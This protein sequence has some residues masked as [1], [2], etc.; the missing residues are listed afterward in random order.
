[1]GLHPNW[2]PLLRERYAHAFLTEVPSHDR[3]Q[4]AQVMLI[5]FL[6]VLFRKSASIRTGRHFLNFVCKLIR[7][8][9]NEGGETCVI[10]IDEL[11]K[12]PL[13]KG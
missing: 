6:P 7:A 1:M 10:I 4:S 3:S 13:A 2:K 8:F 12:V 9:F 5:D 11:A